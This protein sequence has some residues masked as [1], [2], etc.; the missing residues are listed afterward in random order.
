MN[1]VNKS[2]FNYLIIELNNS[3]F[4]VKNQHI[5]NTYGFKWRSGEKI[6]FVKRS[7]FV[8]LNLNDLEMTHTTFPLSD[9]YPS[10][11]K[12]NYDKI[13][14]ICDMRKIENFLMTN[15]LN[16]PNYKSKKIER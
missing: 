2:K 10:L 1:F 11:N 4:S 12:M 14:N 3:D 5:F 8:F 13:Y 6:I 7:S 16:S 15:G 9:I